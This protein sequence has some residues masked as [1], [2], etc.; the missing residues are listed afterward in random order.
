MTFISGVLWVAGAAAG[1]LALT[2]V[3][4]HVARLREEV[5]E[6]RAQSP[7]APPASKRTA[8]VRP[9]F[10]ELYEDKPGPLDG[11]STWPGVPMA[12]AAAGLFAIGIVTGRPGRMT[13]GQADSTVAVE[14][15]AARLRYDSLATEVSQLRDSVTAMQRRPAVASSTHEAAPRRVRSSGSTAMARPP[16]PPASNA[17]APLPSLP[18]VGQ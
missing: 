14:L 7:K 4:R 6:L 12:F 9:M 10:G 18:K 3:A 17:I 5:D 8:D 1:V 11:L 16:E 15:A 2:Q 13:R